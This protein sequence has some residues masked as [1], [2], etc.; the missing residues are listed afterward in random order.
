MM[1]S[2][3]IKPSLQPTSNGEEVHIIN[4][5]ITIELE[6]DESQ[7]VLPQSYSDKDL[8]SVV[9]YQ[10]LPTKQSSKAFYWVNA[11]FWCTIIY[12]INYS[13]VTTLGFR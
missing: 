11:Q 2:L 6:P 5:V 7:P 12:N 9:Q 10:V 4:D 3:R 8:G 1:Y 13:N